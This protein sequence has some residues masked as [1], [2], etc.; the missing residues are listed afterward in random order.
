MY[1]QFS[2]LPGAIM[3]SIYVESCRGEISVA[4]EIS[5]YYVIILVLLMGDL[6]AEEVR[7]AHQ[8]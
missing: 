5:R 1:L 3:V 8:L 4:L 7:I 6:K 2:S